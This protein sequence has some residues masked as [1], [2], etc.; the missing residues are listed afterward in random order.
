MKT[1][2]ER[3]ESRGGETGEA[4]AVDDEDNEGLRVEQTRRLLHV[5]ASVASVID[6]PLENITG[7]FPKAEGRT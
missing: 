5:V 6:L 4:V 7:A 2:N 1:L 3:K